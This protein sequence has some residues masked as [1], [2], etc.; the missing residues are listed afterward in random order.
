MSPMELASRILAGTPPWVWAVLGLLIVLGVRR[1]RPRRT[2][3]AIAALAPTAFTLWSLT[4]V[5]AAARVGSTALVLGV[6]AAALAAGAC[7][8]LVHRGPRP[9][10]Q[11]GGVF[12]FAGSVVPLLIYLFVFLARY[13][14][15]VWSALEPDLARPLSLVAIAISAATAG[16]FIADLLPLL[17]AA[18]RPVGFPAQAGRPT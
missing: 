10:P 3:L 11:G 4:A 9:E 13:V 2:H 14:L 7:T 8:V 5:A 17:R 15:G 18:G 1:L 6:W 12:L 16:R